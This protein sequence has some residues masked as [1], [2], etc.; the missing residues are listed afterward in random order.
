MK[1]CTGNQNLGGVD[2]DNAM[3][4][5]FI[6]KIKEEHDVDISENSK[7]KTRLRNACK[8]AK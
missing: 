6:E 1:A 3:M 4:D 7:A 8:E 5:Y 2:I